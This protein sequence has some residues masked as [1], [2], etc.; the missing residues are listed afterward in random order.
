MG[1]R[2]TKG[3]HINKNVY[4][5]C[6]L[7]TQRFTCNA[8]TATTIMAFDAPQ[9]IMQFE[10][11]IA[12]RLLTSEFCMTAPSPNEI[13]FFARTLFSPNRTVMVATIICHNITSFQFLV[14]SNNA[15]ILHF[16]PHKE[17]PHIFTLAHCHRNCRHQMMRERGVCGKFHW[18]QM[19]FYVFCHFI[20]VVY[21][22][23]HTKHCSHSRLSLSPFHMTCKFLIAMLW[24]YVRIFICCIHSCA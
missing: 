5:L 8:L 3:M 19:R 21:C 1:E 20:Y 7:Q 6:V 23:F 2:E 22:N 24:F 18:F 13:G 14:Y 11:V 9:H 10:Y 16:V 4:L 17:W 15:P 12:L